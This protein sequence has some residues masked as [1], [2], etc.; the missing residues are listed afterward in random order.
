MLCVRRRLAARK[1]LRPPEHDY[2][3]PFSLQE[4]WERTDAA[5]MY[6]PHGQGSLMVRM[7]AATPGGWI[8]PALDAKWSPVDRCWL[9]AR[10]AMTRVAKG[11]IGL[12]GKVYVIQPLDGSSAC[13][14]ACARA[15]GL[16]C[17]CSCL[18]RNHG[19][20]SPHRWYVYV[21]GGSGTWHGQS[22]RWSLL[23]PP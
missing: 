1:V 9:I 17:R 23:A 6:L 20:A 11:L 13:C 3:N 8:R 21:A 18:G 2:S 22:M 19:A 12:G 16:E 15:E 14:A 5:V 10:G 7:P 4:I